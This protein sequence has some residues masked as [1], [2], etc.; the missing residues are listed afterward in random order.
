[1]ALKR[2]GQ[3]KLIGSFG[4]GKADRVRLRGEMQSNT[5]PGGGPGG[6]GSSGWQKGAGGPGQN[7]H[8][9]LPPQ[10]SPLSCSQFLASNPGRYVC[11]KFRI[12]RTELGSEWWGN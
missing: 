8:S 6:R 12:V 4:G 1:M 9:Q 5:T 11:P 10:S 3:Q 7:C 2:R